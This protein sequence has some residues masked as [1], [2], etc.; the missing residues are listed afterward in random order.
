MFETL[1]CKLCSNLQVTLNIF[2]VEYPLWE[3]ME[4]ALISSNFGFVARHRTALPLSALVNTLL[5]EFF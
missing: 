3:F 1:R 4:T 2:T 5:Y